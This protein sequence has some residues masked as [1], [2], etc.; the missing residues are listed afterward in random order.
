MAY[1]D[2]TF[3]RDGTLIKTSAKVHAG[4]DSSKRGGYPFSGEQR[5]DYRGDVTLRVAV[6]IFS[7]FV[8]N[9][10]QPD[11]AFDYRQ[12]FPVDFTAQF[13]DGMLQAGI[14]KGR[15]AISMCLSPTLP[16]IVTSNRKPAVNWGPQIIAEYRNAAYSLRHMIVF[17]MP[18]SKRGDYRDWDLLPFL[19]GGLV[20][21]NRRRH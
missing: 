13:D 1:I 12:V 4:W 17:N 2:T 11:Q 19:P 6:W 7:T 9:D 18:S 15:L 21:R 14:A 3:E 16:W 8:V 10:V 5:V 20:E